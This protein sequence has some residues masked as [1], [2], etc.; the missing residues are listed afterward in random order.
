MKDL[1]DYAYIY[2]KIISSIETHVNDNHIDF[3]LF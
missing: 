3:K 2:V 1:S